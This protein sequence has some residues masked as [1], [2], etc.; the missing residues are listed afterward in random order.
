VE[1]EMRN[2]LPL[3]EWIRL[4]TAASLGDI[5]VGEM[6]TVQII[7]EPG[8]GVND[9]IYELNLKVKGDNLSVYTVPVFIKVTQSGI[10]NAFFKISDI[11]TS[12]L[13]ANKQII[14]GVN[15]ARVQL[16]HETVPSISR[17]L[18]TDAKGEVIFEAIPAGRYTYRITADDHNSASGRI[19]IKPD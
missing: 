16:Q 2:K 5:P 17:T 14:E 7:A 1:L 3:P 18:N 12:T 15:R 10:G 8:V 6:R 4:S 11:Y 9:G 13:D 19:W